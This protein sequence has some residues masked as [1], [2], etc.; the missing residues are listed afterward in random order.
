M[1]NLTINYSSEYE[2]QRIKYTLEKLQW[3]R[4]NKYNVSLP[5]KLVADS[6]IVISED[7]IKKLVDVEYNEDD[8]KTQEKF[9]LEKWQKLVDE[10]W[11]EFSK[12]SLSPLNTYKIYMTKY[13]VGGSYNLPDSIIINIK[14]TYNIG[15]LRTAFHE[16]VH[17]LIQPWIVEY[18]V[19][20]W[21][22]ERIVD[23]LLLKFI[24]R[25]AKSQQTRIETEE[26]DKIF[27]ENYPN[28]ELIVKN[29]GLAN[30][31][32]KVS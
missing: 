28:V 26:V 19:S 32:K 10:S 4:D 11:S 6:D 9:L 21:Q 22:K 2:I 18:K 20:H 29:V 1:I 13:G 5:E 25:L 31:S 14:Y 16:M 8:Y 30:L 7:E 12:T 24:P 3:Y 23:L 15:L 27:D 17:L